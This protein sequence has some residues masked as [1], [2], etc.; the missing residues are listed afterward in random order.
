MRRPVKHILVASFLLLAAALAPPAMA[1]SVPPT[2]TYIP[3]SFVKLYQING[4]CDWAE[5]DATITSKTPTCKSTTSQTAT[6]AD[7]LGD[8]VATSLEQESFGRAVFVNAPKLGA[9]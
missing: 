9:I 5:W 3:G 2:L 8:D 4:D 7:V 6:K 1:Q